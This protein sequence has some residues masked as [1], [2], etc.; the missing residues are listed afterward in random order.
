MEILKE[1][2]MPGQIIA[3]FAALLEAV[4][5]QRAKKHSILWW[6]I[7]SDILFAT[8]YLV[9][10]LKS[11]A[12]IVVVD[13]IITFINYK[14]ALKEKKINK[15]LGVLFIIIAIATSVYT[16]QSIV[17]ILPII[18]SITF[19][20]SVMQTK[21][22][23]IRRLVFINLVCWF[24]YDIYGHAYV[25]MVTDFITLVSTITGIIRYDFFKKGK[26]ED[27]NRQTYRK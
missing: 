2:I 13:T 11:A 22:K 24:T 9:L 17:D 15:W 25:T 5:V 6:F 3:I 21:E 26:K 14:L 10:G 12:I 23:N 27:D 16:Y 18:C 7:L 19:T 4:A 1:L 8:S 20:L